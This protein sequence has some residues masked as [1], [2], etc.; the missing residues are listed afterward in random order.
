MPAVMAWELSSS[1]MNSRHRKRLA[2]VYVRQSTLGQVR[3]HPESTRLQYAL[4]ERAVGLGW[5]ADRVVVIDEDLGRS[6]T[7][8]AQR[9]GFQRLVTEIS[10]GHVGLV[11]GIDMSR[12]ARCGRDW[13]QLIELCALAGTL[14]ADTLDGTTNI[15]AADRHYARNP[16][17]SLA[18]LGTT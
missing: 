9:T 10:L 14:L 17:R 12:L 7:G 4:A 15:S 11:V 16:N 6:G 3:D 13:Y 18:L 2:V 5:P 8:T 1:K